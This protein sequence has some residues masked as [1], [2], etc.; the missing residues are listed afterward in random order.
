MSNNTRR[1]PTRR[2]GKGYHN[3]VSMSQ[4]VHIS[5]GGEVKGTKQKAE[6]ELTGGNEQYERGTARSEDPGILV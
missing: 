5:H 3:S 4:I 1:G 6:S 2:R